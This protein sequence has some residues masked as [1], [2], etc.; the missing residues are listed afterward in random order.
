LT[1]PNL[2]VVTVC[3]NASATIE[4][5]ICSVLDQDYGSCEHLII[6]GG[7]TDGTLDIIRRH[8]GD[9]LRYVSEPD[10]GLY[11]AMNKGIRLSRGEWIHLLNSDDRYY[12]RASLT[13]AVAALDPDKTN[14]FA[15]EHE[16]VNGTRSSYK[17]HF[18][19]WLLLYSAYLP[20]PGLVVSREQYRKVGLYDTSLRIAADHDLILRMLKEYPVKIHRLPLVI[21]RQGGISTQQTEKAFKEFAD[22]VVRHGCPGALARIFYFI[23]LVRHRLRSKL[24]RH[25]RV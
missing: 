9:R 18:N 24:A 19:R 8:A 16:E 21:M 2:S 15:I 13:R 23:K 25:G 1:A 22:V 6:D 20:H 5:T 14:S 3:L 10:Q 4:E 11:D 7:S 17:S 12:D